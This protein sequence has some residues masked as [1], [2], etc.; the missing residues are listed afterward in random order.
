MIFN[1]ISNFQIPTF[2]PEHSGDGKGGS[3]PGAEGD[4]RRSRG[5]K[6]L[7]HHHVDSFGRSHV[8]VGEI[9]ILN[10]SIL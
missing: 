4:L 5:R 2:G 1:V 9:T 10:F 6:A 3:R 7:Q 8:Q